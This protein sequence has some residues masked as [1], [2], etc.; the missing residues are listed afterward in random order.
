MRISGN[1][2]GRRHV[3]QASQAVLGTPT[4]ASHCGRRLG[5]DAWAVRVCAFCCWIFKAPQKTVVIRATHE[6]VP[7]T[8]LDPWARKSKSL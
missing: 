7:E 4:F 1:G 8:S 2:L 3:Q 6:L 5:G